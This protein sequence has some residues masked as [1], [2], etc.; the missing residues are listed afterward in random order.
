MYT[1]F[2]DSK[3]QTGESSDFKLADYYVLAK[4]GSESRRLRILRRAYM[5]LSFVNRS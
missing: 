2:I 4:G 3:F 5:L 1:P